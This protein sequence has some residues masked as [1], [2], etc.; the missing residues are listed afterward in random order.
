MRWLAV[1]LV[2]ALEEG[3]MPDSV[4]LGDDHVFGCRQWAW[5]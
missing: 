4:Y 2:W 3:Y 1:E 5:Q